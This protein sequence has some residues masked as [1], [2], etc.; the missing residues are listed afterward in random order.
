MPCISWKPW[1]FNKHLSLD[2][3]YV[4]ANIPPEPGYHFR[5][6]GK[7]PDLSTDLMNVMNAQGAS[8]EIL[9]GFRFRYI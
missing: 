5:G 2:A 1:R 3:L 7:L 6:R 8:K 9:A 4:V